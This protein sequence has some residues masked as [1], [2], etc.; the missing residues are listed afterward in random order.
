MVW[1]KPAV[2]PAGLMIYTGTLFPDWRGNGFMSGLSGEVLLRIVFDGDRAHEAQRFDMDARIRE[3]EQGPD[4][5]I[6]VLEDGKRDRL[7]R[8]SP[9]P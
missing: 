6:W 3:V 7:L 9:I 4:G 1:W 2:S 8:L 5:A